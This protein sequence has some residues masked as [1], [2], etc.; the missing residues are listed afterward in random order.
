MQRRI[1]LAL[2]L[3]TL[4][5]AQVVAF[6]VVWRFFVRSSHGQLLDSLALAG[7]RIG[8][9][10]VHDRA[11]VVLNT[12]SVVSLAAMTAVVGFIALARRQVALAVG[13]VLLVAGA[14]VT[15]QVAKQVLSRPDFGVD[16][17][18]AAVGNTLPSGH[19]AIAASIVVALV[20]VLPARVRGLAGVIGAIAAAGIGVGTL[21]AGWHRPSDAVAALLLVGAWAAA[22]G[23]FII[24]V[25]RRPEPTGPAHPYAVVALTVAGLMLLAGAGL[26]MMVTDHVR[27][28]P[29]TELSRGRLFAAYAGG[30]MGIA[31]TAGLV[32]ASVL[33]TVHRVAPGAASSKATRI[34][35]AFP[36]P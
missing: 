15:A 21:S 4:G 2:W 28:V 12:I 27:T 23:L 6:W 20:L 18:L 8:R 16:P 25:Q 34:R 1:G 11:D 3:V 31:G 30:A 5:V 24:A 10:R 13:A 32:V 26:A 7:N 17:Q 22:A 35:Q 36:A 9:A 33:A 19:T 29:A 14:S